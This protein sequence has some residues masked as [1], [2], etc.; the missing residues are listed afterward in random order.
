G[1]TFLFYSGTGKSA[2]TR[3][4][5]L[6]M[7]QLGSQ[8][9][10]LD[11][12]ESQFIHNIL[13]LKQYRARQ[14]MTPRTVVVCAPEN[15]TLQEFYDKQDE[16]VFSRIPVYAPDDRDEITGYVLKD[17]VL[18]CL[19]D[20]EKNKTLKEIKRD[21]MCVI[22]N[23]NVFQLFNDLSER[24]EHITL[25]IDEFGGLSGIVSMEDVIET[26]LGLEIVD[27]TDKDVNMQARAKR[28][29]KKRLSLAK[30]IRENNSK[31][32]E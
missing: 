5:F 3:S 25:V 1:F 28:D 27:E 12:V 29:W 31:Q 10:E 13:H 23:Y 19:V 17:E 15:M 16:L 9:G 6:A 2:L 7:A 18:E 20:G 32:T 24:R 30:K 21:V 11:P 14:I 4:D 26:L 8:E 22:E